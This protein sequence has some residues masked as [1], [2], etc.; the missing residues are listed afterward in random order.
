MQA[1]CYSTEA[2]PAPIGTVPV[3]KRRAAATVTAQH[4]WWMHLSAES[5]WRTQFL[6]WELGRNKQEED[7]LRKGFRKLRHEDSSQG[8]E[9]QEEGMLSNMWGHKDLSVKVRWESFLHNRNEEKISWANWNFCKEAVGAQLSL[10]GAQ[11]SSEGAQWSLERAWWTLEGVWDWLAISTQ[12]SG[13]KTSADNALGVCENRTEGQFVGTWV[14]SH[15][16]EN[17]RNQ[18]LQVHKA[19][20]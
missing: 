15:N 3:E 1:N 2:N 7:M 11:W 19:A 9:D 13:S 14:P 5:S 17:H 4:I 8:E 16:S 12:S 20:R 10:A 18:N 6:E